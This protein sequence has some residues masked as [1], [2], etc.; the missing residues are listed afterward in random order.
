MLFVLLLLRPSQMDMLINVTLSTI[1][2]LQPIATEIEALKQIEKHSDVDNAKVYGLP[3]FAHFSIGENA[4]N[5][6]HL[7][8]IGHLYGEYGDEILAVSC[9][10]LLLPAAV[11]HV[12]S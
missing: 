5:R 10:C 9:C 3:V 8:M 6:L 12:L 2:R 11:V 4:L 7:T 1:A